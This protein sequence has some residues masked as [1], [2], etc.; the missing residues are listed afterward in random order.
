MVAG[1]ARIDV[2]FTIDAD[3]L[4]TVTATEQTTGRAQHI[5]V[6]PSYGLSEQDMMTM[7]RSSIE[8]GSDDMHKR[9]LAQG[10]VEGERLLL[11]VRS[12]LEA[13][14]DLCSPAERHNIETACQDLSRA[15]K[16]DKKNVIEQACQ[17]L[18]RATESFAHRR[19]EQAMR[20][21][22]AGKSVDDVAD[23][24]DNKQE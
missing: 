17:M 16:S 13:S 22:L 18:E 3:G 12:A 4:L 15:L 5:E 14:G 10:R 2:N 7:L 21:A 6:K 8:H 9:L 20:S 1:A 11:G 19:M 24:K 23:D